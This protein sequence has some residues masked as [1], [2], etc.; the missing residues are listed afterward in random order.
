MITWRNNGVSLRPL[1]SFR[2]SPSPAGL[3]E[4]VPARVGLDGDMALVR[5]PPTTAP[6]PINAALRVNFFISAKPVCHGLEQCSRM[7]DFV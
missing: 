5:K 2:M 4:R 1:A 3:I 7:A 6:L